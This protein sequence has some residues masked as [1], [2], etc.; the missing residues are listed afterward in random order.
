MGGKAMSK[1]IASSRRNPCPVCD[2]MSGDCRSLDTGLILCHSFIDRHQDPSHPDWE[3][4]KPDK[5]GIWGIFAPRRDEQPQYSRDYWLENAKRVKAKREQEKLERGKRAL[6]LDDRDKWLRV[7][8]SEMG[9]TDGDRQRLRDRGMTDD[10]IAAGLFFSYRPGQ[11]VSD[12]IP[13]NLPGIR[14]GKLAGRHPG[15]ACIAFDIDGKAIGYQVRLNAVT[16]GGKYR[17]G[18]GQASSHLPNGELPLSVAK[19]TNRV[20]P[21]IGLSEGILKPFVAAGRLGI[22]FIGAAGGNH[23]GSPEQLKTALDALLTDDPEQWIVISPDA[24][25]ILNKNVLRQYQATVKLITDWGHGDRLRFGW[26]GQITKD[27]QDCDEIG[28]DTAIE[29]LTVDQF[30]T[31]AWQQQQWD[32]WRKSKQFTAAI[33]LDQRF[34]NHK[35]FQ[36]GFMYFVKSGLGS[37]KSFNTRQWIDENREWLEHNRIHQQGYRNNLLLQD[38]ERTPG[39]IHIHQFKQYDGLSDPDLWAAYCLDSIIK[40][41]PENFDN[42]VIILDEIVSVIKHLLSANTEI[43]KYR[44]KAILLF[45]EAIK[46]ARLVICLDGNMADWVVEFMQGICDKKIQTI[47]NTHPTPRPDL[48]WVEGSISTNAMGETFSENDYR[49]IIDLLYG[50]PT[51]RNIPENIKAKA[52]TS[53]SQTCL[54]TID[55]L[56]TKDGKITLRIDRTTAG[57]EIVKAFL[58]DPVKWLLENQIDYLLYSPTAESGLDIPIENYFAVHYC[59]FFGVLDVDSTLQM[60]ARIRDVACPKVVWARSWSTNQDD[61]K[62]PTAEVIKRAMGDRVKLDLDRALSGENHGSEIISQILETYQRT[63]APFEDTAF[64]L[65]AQ[66]NFE[67][68]NYRECLLERLKATGYPEIITLM[69][70]TKDKGKRYKPEKLEVQLQESE[71]IFDAEI[72]PVNEL[73]PDKLADQRSLRKI[74]ILDQLPGIDHDPIWS[75]DFIFKIL[76][77][78][79]QLISQVRRAWMLD[80]PDIVARLDLEKCKRRHDR[81]F[82]GRASLLWR[83]RNEWGKLWALSECIAPILNHPDPD[84]IWT[85]DDPEIQHAIEQGKRKAIYLH[86]GRQGKLAPLQYV[87]RLFGLIGLG[88]E[89]KVIKRDDGTMSREYRINRKQWETAEWQA[90]TNSL[91]YKWAKYID[92]DFAPIDWQVSPSYYQKMPQNVLP[93]LRENHPTQTSLQLDFQPVAPDPIFVIE[94]TAPGATKNVPEKTG[95]KEPSEIEYIGNEMAAGDNVVSFAPTWDGFIQDAIAELIRLGYSPDQSQQILIDR[96]GKRPRPKLTDE[97]Y[98]DIYNDFMGE[99]YP[100]IADRQN[101]C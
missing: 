87:G 47:E 37:G 19:A 43:D 46:R 20:L 80:H 27:G 35:D 17:W 82:D 61:F 31:L 8:S 93:I 21:H 70:E 83:D 81:F 58:A 16:T 24:G 9:L 15:I 97:D 95:D 56:L 26:W 91:T 2:D 18:Y 71:A 63:L 75:S 28:P 14:W 64:K 92:T 60:M 57:D 40:F 69:P 42:A 68:S 1:I 33:K 38:C 62:S 50:N 39:L 72:K 22:D 85:A 55:S 45:I 94:T 90:M 49:G 32:A 5:S 44:D 99:L 3:Y 36:D 29:Y 7:L 96:Y 48:Y 10:Q 53:D 67:K 23:A 78:D 65:W 84:K 34:F 11:K 13:A 79:R 52:I 54:A 25:A 41:K 30:F 98:A 76:F 74:K 12:K 86:L 77:D 59:L 101:S 88:W 73:N 100:S 4:R 6:S 66:R 89:T 51:N